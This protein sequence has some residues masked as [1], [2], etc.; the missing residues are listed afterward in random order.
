MPLGNH[1]VYLREYAAR[2][3]GIADLCA[4]QDVRLLLMTQPI[5]ALDSSDT[6]RFMELYNT[7]TKQLAQER[8]LPIFDLATAL[9][10]NPSYYLDGIHF[11]NAGAAEVARL[12]APFMQEELK[13]S[14]K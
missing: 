8:G 14:G 11:S 6:R 10:Q 1:E 13:R 4:A 7:A 2:I 12:I 3:A 9:R 5:L